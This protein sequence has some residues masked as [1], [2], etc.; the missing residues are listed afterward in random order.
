[1]G[2]LGLDRGAEAVGIAGREQYGDGIG[3][4]GRHLFQRRE[5][6]EDPEASP[7]GGHRHVVKVLL[8]GDPVDRRVRQV[9][10]HRLPVL[11]AVEREVE[12]VLGAGEEQ[13]AAHRVLADAMSVAEH[14]MGNAIGDSSPGLAVVGGLEEEKIAIVHLMAIHGDVGGAVGVARGFDVRHRSPLGHAGDIGR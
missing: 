11:A 6:V 14:A 4:L 13:S 5:V 9:G 8:H 2:A 7:I 12:A 1:M 10:L 3:G